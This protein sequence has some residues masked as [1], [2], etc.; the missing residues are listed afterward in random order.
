M[1]LQYSPV[2]YISVIS[3]LF[4]F[5]KYDR[6]RERI[7]F[8][9]LVSGMLTSFFDLLTYPLLTWGMPALWLILIKEEGTV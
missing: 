4:V 2:F 6:Y 1:S 7:F 9:F 3:T 8:I 5:L